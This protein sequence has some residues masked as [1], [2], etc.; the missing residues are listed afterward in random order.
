MNK[1]NLHNGYILHTED[2]EFL[3]Q[4]IYK[5]TVDRNSRFWT[6]GVI[7]GLHPIDVEG[8][9]QIQPGSAFINGKYIEF[10][11]G[12]IRLN[13]ASPGKVV[14]LKVDE[15]NQYH[16]N[17][18]EPS[19]PSTNA[20]SEGKLKADDGKPPSE[21]TQTENTNGQLHSTTYVGRVYR[22]STVPTN[23]IQL[24]YF[25]SSEN[26]TD[27]RAFCRLKYEIITAHLATKN[28]HGFMSDSDKV[29]LDTIPVMGSATD[30]YLSEELR[31]KLIQMPTPFEGDAYITTTEKTHLN[32]FPEVRTG[33]SFLSENL[34]NKL[35]AVPTPFSGC[36]FLSKEQRE[37]FNNI[38][39][40][41]SGD[42]FLTADEHTKLSK[43]P[44]PT[45]V[46]GVYVLKATE[47][48]NE[49]SYALVPEMDFEKRVNELLEQKAK[50]GQ[51]YNLKSDF[52]DEGNKVSL[53]W[54]TL[55]GEGADRFAL[56]ISQTKN[57]SADVREINTIEK[58]KRTYVASL[59]S[60][61][62]SKT[63]YFKLSYYD[64]TTGAK[65]LSTY[66]SA[67][68]GN[69]PQI[70]PI[71]DVR[72]D[73]GKTYSFNVNAVDPRG[74]KITYS[75]VQ[76]SDAWVTLNTTSGVIN[77]APPAERSALGERT[78]EVQAKNESGATVSV[79][80]KLIVTNSA[81]V[82]TNISEKVFTVGHSF[83]IPVKATDNNGSASDIT[84]S[85]SNP[86]A[87]V[88]ISSTGVIAG[89]APRNPSLVYPYSSYV[90]V[91]ATD[92]FGAS[93][94][95]TFRLTS[96]N[97]NP[98]I[99]GFNTPTVH[100]GDSFNYKITATDVDGH[101]V[102]YSIVGEKPSWISSINASTGVLSGTAP[103]IASDRTYSLTVKAQDVI[104]ENGSKQPIGKGTLK[105][106]DIVVQNQAPRILPIS[107]ISLKAGVEN[108]S[109]VL[110]AENADND[111]LTWS[112]LNKPTWLSI[113][114]NGQN[115]ALLTVSKAPLGS[116]NLSFT[117]KVV[118][119]N[120]A[121]DTEVLRFSTTNTAP[122]LASVPSQNLF[123]GQLFE[124]QMQV[125]DDDTQHH[126]SISGNGSWLSISNSGLLSGE[127]PNASGEE[128]ISV[129]VTDPSGAKD[130]KVFTLTYKWKPS[131]PVIVSA[132]SLQ[133]IDYL[134]PIDPDIRQ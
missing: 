41:L 89:K 29:K 116:K 49:L 16:P 55:E 6:D 68:I 130:T 57:F 47:A 53:T 32:S 46:D 120:G 31:N 76:N 11:S 56:S 33:D 79:T 109:V 131:V 105:R 118:D 26:Y 93:S 82:I 10:T 59:T 94:T 102:V 58:D 90:T 100:A 103:N 75:F 84:W 2:L 38:P 74:Q 30:M 45:S 83:S 3:Q 22:G 19:N 62:K 110:T 73:A 24:G 9:T 27:D 17:I 44:D 132:T 18:F 66:V 121:S 78:I 98:T 15:E 87:G 60:A 85:L 95:T 106:F 91:Q 77:V 64:S 117:V 111:V 14:Y 88:T 128:K 54:E 67:F 97:T 133:L 99:N 125:T 81:P 1:L 69:E 71:S 39:H 129:T 65:G 36:S 4:S 134:D 21:D 20:V 107:P 34:R 101:D 61:E 92:K 70:S 119:E 86:P 126:W 40:P 7:N 112:V 123:P 12:Q 51:T 35:N 96:K 50:M 114:R 108:H 28:A 115:T 8:Q 23:G 124:H 25:D 127:V 104:D 5:N 48:N 37:T 80:F 52:Q 113:A 63:L 13:E 122:V 42:R 43:L 72:V